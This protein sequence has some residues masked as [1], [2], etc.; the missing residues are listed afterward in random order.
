V[1][2]EIVKANEPV[3][4]RHQHTCIYLA[5]DDKSRYSND[6]GSEFEVY[7]HNHSTKNKS[8][9]LALENQG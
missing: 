5:A 7:C 4:I 2:G 6:F 9:N 3:L 1:Q 8:Q